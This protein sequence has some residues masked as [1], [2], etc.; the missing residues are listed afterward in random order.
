VT[1]GLRVAAVAALLLLGFLLQAYFFHAYPQPVL[2]GDPAGYASVGESFQQALSRVGKG[3]S[4]WAAFESVRGLFYLLG[5]GLLFAALDALRPGDLGFARLVMAA[6][7][8]L[9]MAGVFLLARRLA[10]SFAGGLCALVIAATYATFAVQTGRL[11]PDPVT[12]CLFVWAAFL[13]ADAA[14]S[15]RPRR[16]LAAGLTFTAALFVRSQIITYL[17]LVIVLA[18]VL[19]ASRWA[20]DGRARR[21]VGAFLLGLAPL[22]LLWGVITWS[23][24]ARDDVIR[25]GN[26]TFKPYYPY[27]FWQFLETDGWIGPYRFK[28]EPFYKAMEQ[29]SLAR[30]PDLLRSRTRQW[31]FT[32]RYVA[33][34]PVD[35]LLLVLDNAYRLYDRPANDYKWDYPYPYTLQVGAQ[36]LILVL[37]LAGAAVF[38]AARPAWAGVFL[39]PAALAVLHGLVFPWPRYNVPAMPIL[40]AS[41]GAFLAWLRTRLDARGVWRDHTMAALAVG[42]VVCTVLGHLLRMTAPGPA[43][44]ARILGLLAVLALPFVLAHRASGRSREARATTAAAYAVLSLCTLAH[45]ARDQRWHEVA[46]TL[47]GDVLAVEQEIRLSPEALGRLRTAP[48]A[49]V[50]LDLRVPRGDL[51]GA[52]LHIGA[53]ALKGAEIVPTIPRLRESTSTGGRDRRAYPQW[54]AARLDPAWLPAS[55]ADPLRVRLEVPVGLEAVLGADRFAGQDQIYEGPSFGDWP[56]FVALKLEYD[57]D[58]R[59][60]VRRELGSAGTR[61][62]VVRREGTSHATRAVHRIR[63]VTL[64]NN[65][66]TLDWESEPP[67]RAGPVAHAFAAY[68]GNRGTATIAVNGVP[69]ITLPLGA[70]QDFVQEQPPWRLCYR[71]EAPR[72][73]KAYGVYFLVGPAGP[74]GAPVHLS[75]RFHTGPSLDPMFLVLDRKRP[76]AELEALFA[77]CGSPAVPVVALGRVKDATRNNYPEDTGRWTVSGIY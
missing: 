40:I 15:A 51:Q 53:H 12:A 1:R 43:R 21:L 56:H 44:A 60:S 67:S 17:L 38:V 57:A 26:A 30:D 6:F 62:A 16:M 72:Q 41:A 4:A 36:R 49:F 5:V 2:F 9:A 73:D 14:E 34:R 42:A 55:A 54:W 28:Q 52:T 35:S 7:N 18:L 29:E 63:L 13:Y 39:I 19:S 77:G 76:R 48:E 46:T 23:V 25:L 69:A 33:A 68:S 65:V 31:T 8:T 58:Y 71:A 22:V 20:R 75:A 27:G 11:Y 74:S 50:M 24:G 47:G 45:A 32:A 66:G 3:E 61:S 59:L 10:G 37:G 70:R 64:G